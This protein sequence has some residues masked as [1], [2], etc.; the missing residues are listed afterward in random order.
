MK[1]TKQEDKKENNEVEDEKRRKNRGGGKEKNTVEKRRGGM[2][3]RRRSTA[4]TKTKARGIGGGGEGET[5]RPLPTLYYHSPSLPTLYFLSPFIII[6]YL[7]LY[8][9]EMRRG[10]SLFFWIQDLEQVIFQGSQSLNEEIWA[11]IK[12]TFA[13]IFTQTPSKDLHDPPYD[14]IIYTVE[15]SVEGIE[16]GKLGIVENLITYQLEIYPSLL[17]ETHY[18]TNSPAIYTTIVAMIVLAT[19]EIF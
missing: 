4:T 6:R 14:S 3:V 8:S 2:W 5:A 18:V 16:D 9:Q 15:G 13:F 11:Q 19:S 10:L 12:P 7:L 17:F 1:T